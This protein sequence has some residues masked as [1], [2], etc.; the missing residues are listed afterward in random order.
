MC[1]LFSFTITLQFLMPPLT[2]FS[3]SAAAAADAA[4]RRLDIHLWVH[5]GHE[6]SVATTA[7]TER[8]NKYCPNGDISGKIQSNPVCFCFIIRLTI[9]IG[10]CGLLKA[11]VDLLLREIPAAQLQLNCE[12]V[13]LSKTK[14]DFSKR[15]TM[16]Y[17]FMLE[18]E[19]NMEPA[20]LRKEVIVNVDKNKRKGSFSQRF[21]RLSRRLRCLKYWRDGG[22]MDLCGGG[23]DGERPMQ[24][25][26]RPQTN[27][28]AET[29]LICQICKLLKDSI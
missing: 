6:P 28:F 9:Y 24:I 29:Q 10:G 18:T 14:I 22:K 27:T 16:D 23:G 1:E 21:Q 15:G 13:N 7:K 3:C 19:L 2:L 5:C 26:V 17:L 11:K 12:C 25:K 8:R 4:P 20:T